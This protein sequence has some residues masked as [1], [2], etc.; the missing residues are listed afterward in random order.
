MTLQEGSI[1]FMVLGE[2]WLHL[3]LEVKR[4]GKTLV[5]QLSENPGGLYKVHNQLAGEVKLGQKGSKNMVQIAAGKTT[6]WSRLDPNWEKDL[7]LEVDDQCFLITDKQLSQ[8]EPKILLS[9]S[10]P[11]RVVYVQITDGPCKR[12][13]VMD[14][15]PQESA[16]MDTVSQA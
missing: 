16:V 9:F 10:L 12:V 2:D 8:H 13:S 11:D 4:V 15:P 1:P 3:M 6:L 7:K 5:Y 14:T